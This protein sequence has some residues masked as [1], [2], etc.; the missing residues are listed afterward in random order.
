MVCSLNT[1]DQRQRRALVAPS[2]L[3]VADRADDPL[4]L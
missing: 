3:P 1:L 2:G 4:T